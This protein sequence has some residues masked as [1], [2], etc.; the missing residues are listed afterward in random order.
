[1]NR[2]V[3]ELGHLI[4]SFREQLGLTQHELADSVRSSRSAIALM[5]QG[6]RLLNADALRTVSHFLGIPD[7]VV[8]PFMSPAF[9][10]RRNKVA[11]QPA[12]FVPFQ[13]LCVSGITGSGKTTLAKVIART[14]GIERIGSH[15][16]GLAYLRDLADNE[17]RWAFEAQVAFLV[18]KAGQI[19]EKL[20]QGKPLVVERWIEEDILVYERLF[21]ESG[22]IN[23]R[24]HETFE[25]V[26]NVARKFL[27]LPEPEFHF[28]CDC[29]AETALSRVSRRGRSDSRLHTIDYID[30][31]KQLALHL[32]HRYQSLYKLQL[33]SAIFQQRCS[34][35]C[36]CFAKAKRRSVPQCYSQ[37]ARRRASH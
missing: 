14:F 20:D 21:K 29:R 25:Q 19:R 27:S 1:M 28:Y 17:D 34:R 35:F 31:S 23:S 32:S 24:S 36:C 13:V 3:I 15:P 8:A 7:N 9:Q 10:S 16:T 33:Q 37:I 22:A 11:P 30:R 4:R 18:T 2:S 6:R 12:T 5:E 26:S